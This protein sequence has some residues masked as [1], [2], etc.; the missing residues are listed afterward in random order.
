MNSRWN[1]TNSSIKGAMTIKVP[2]QISPHSAPDSDARVK[3]WRPTARTR[4]GVTGRRHQGPEEFVPVVDQA[5]HGEGG[6]MRSDH[7][8]EHVPQGAHPAGPVQHGRLIVLRRDAA[9]P[10]ADEEDPVGA[11]DVRHG[12]ARERVPE[13]EGA[14]R[15]EVREDQDDRRQE[16][17]QEHDVEDALPAREPKAGEGVGSEG[18][19]DELDG[20]KAHCV[21]DRVAVVEDEGRRLPRHREVLERRREAP[22]APLAELPRWGEG[23]QEKERDRPEERQGQQERGP[24]T[25]HSEPL[26]RVAA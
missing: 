24:V 16:Q 18:D 11:R 8:H 20:E 25:P 6:E 14:E 13:P 3:D 19:R 7:R 1:R 10:L 9:E 23:R 21:Q 17:L 22:V 26:A 2:A 4:V 12:E 5:H 15:E